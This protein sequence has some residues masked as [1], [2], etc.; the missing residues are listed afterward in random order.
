MLIAKR[1]VLRRSS[2]RIEFLIQKQ[3]MVC[4]TKNEILIDSLTLSSAFTKIFSFCSLF[5]RIVT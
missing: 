3:N 2:G 4:D 5:Q 1:T